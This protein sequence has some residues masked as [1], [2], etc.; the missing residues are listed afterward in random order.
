[1]VYARIPPAMAKSDSLLP[2][3]LSCLHTRMER[4]SPIPPTHNRPCPLIDISS[5][6][7]SPFT[8]SPQHPTTSRLWHT[9]QSH[10]VDIPRSSRVVQHTPSIRREISHQMSAQLIRSL[11]QDHDGAESG[12]DSE[13]STSVAS[14]Q[15]VY[16]TTPHLK[17]VNAQLAELEP[18]GN[19]QR[20]SGCVE[21]LL[22]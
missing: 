19:T 18:E 22:C 8:G 5:N 2:P 14:V 12:Y 11:S 13:G 1:M 4:Y 20:R 7:H 10:L 21:R 9:L 6:A 17:Y 15:S 3:V 16:F